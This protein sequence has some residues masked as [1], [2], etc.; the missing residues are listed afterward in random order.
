MLNSYINVI[1]I[2]LFTIFTQTACNHSNSLLNK[3]LVKE[4]RAVKWHE[5][6]IQNNSPDVSTYLGGGMLYYGLNQTLASKVS[7]IIGSG[8]GFVPRLVA[9]A[10]RDSGTKNGYTYYIDADIKYDPQ[11]GQEYGKPEIEK[12]KLDKNLFLLK[13]RSSYAAKLFEKEGI[14]INYLHIDG[15]HS[16]KG[17]LE[18]WNFFY[19]LLSENAIVTFHDYSSVPDVKVALE[20]IKKSHPDINFISF[21]NAGAGITLAQIGGLEVL[22]SWWGK[23]NKYLLSYFKNNRDTNTLEM[24]D[25]FFIPESGSKENTTKHWSYLTTQPFLKRYELARDFL[26]DSN[27]IIEIGGFPN[28]M[29]YFIPEKLKTI[30]VIEP[31]GTNEWVKNI[32]YESMKRK[33]DLNIIP[34]LND[35]NKFDLPKE[36]GVVWLGANISYLNQVEIKNLLKIL[37]NSRRTVIELPKYKPAEILWDFVKKTL[38]PKIVKT[39]ELKIE[40][41]QTQYNQRNIYYISGFNPSPDYLSDEVI[42]S[43]IDKR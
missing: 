12:V 37:V 15:D 5:S 31:F 25:A 38:N 21:P 16:V 32:S 19:P 17:I 39:E 22:Y 9:Q 8:A 41:D 2:L 28:S 40:T 18:D 14:K 24:E 26:K 11:T 20:I 35:I 30:S 36:Y 23:G 42:K 7:V 29:V 10:Q 1:F 4:Y 27:N 6:H 33:I 43:F 34:S 13:M 3:K